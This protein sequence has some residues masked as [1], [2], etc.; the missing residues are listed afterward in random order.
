MAEGTDGPPG[1]VDEY[2]AIAARWGFLPEDVSTPVRIYQGAADTFPQG[3]AAHWPSEY[4]MPPSLCTAVRG[5]SSLSLADKMFSSGSLAQ[6]T[7][8]NTE[9]VRNCSLT[10]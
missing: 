10:L 4:Q 3:N 7:R 2:L 5:T 8:R 1:V 9:T 6:E